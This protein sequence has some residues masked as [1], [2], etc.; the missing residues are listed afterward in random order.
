M[1]EPSN[2]YFLLLFYVHKLPF[3]IS[4]QDWHQRFTESTFVPFSQIGTVCTIYSL[5]AS[6]PGSIVPE[7]LPTVFL[8]INSIDSPASICP[9]WETQAHSKPSVLLP[10][11]S[12][13]LYD[14]HA[15]PLKQE[16]GSW[17]SELEAGKSW[18]QTQILSLSSSLTLEYVI[19]FFELQFAHL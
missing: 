5:L 13:C 2:F 6:P 16:Q 9:S 4:A 8:Y 15:A 19:Q 14:Q 11:S 1:L 3:K 7:K 12:W 10:S 17:Y 18:M